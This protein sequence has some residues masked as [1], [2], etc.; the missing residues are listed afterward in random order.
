LKNLDN[1]DFKHVDKLIQDQIILEGKDK[2]E[3]A[4]KKV[5]IL[6]LLWG[7]PLLVLLVLLLDLLLVLLLLLKM[8]CLLP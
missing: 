5:L 3:K 7:V 8:N 1:H 2:L 6:V 4:E